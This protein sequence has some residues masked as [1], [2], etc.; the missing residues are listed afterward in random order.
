VAHVFVDTSAVYA[1]LDRD[2]HHHADAEKR[3]IALRRSRLQ[4][5]LTNFVVAECHALFLARLGPDLARRWLLTNVWHIERVTADDEDK[6]RDIIR[7]Y[8]DKSFSYT[9]A[10]SFAVMERLR[11]RRA[12]AF[13]RHFEQYGFDLVGA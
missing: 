3:L 12:L 13:D 10:T 8:V 11:L 6:A 2:D 9:D 5:L 4:P 1:L 7:T